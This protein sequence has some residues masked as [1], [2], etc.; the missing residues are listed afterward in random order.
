[1]TLCMLVKVLKKQYKSRVGLFQVYAM[2]CIK[3][4]TH[5]TRGLVPA[6]S[7][8]DKSHRVNWPFLKSSRRDQLW[9][10]RPV[11]RIQT[12]LNFWDKSLRPIPS[13]KLFRVLVHRHATKLKDVKSISTK[14]MYN[15]LKTPNWQEA[16]QLNIY[17]HDR[18]VVAEW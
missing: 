14:Y 12:N 18:G 8:G 17:K 7:R 3:G 6:T 11:L 10:L 15:R 1:M 2:S 5:A 16:D 9:S 4:G 13:C